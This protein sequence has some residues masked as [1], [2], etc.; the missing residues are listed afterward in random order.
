VAL[1]QVRAVARRDEPGEQMTKRGVRFVAEPLAAAGSGT[2]DER[3]VVEQRW[4]A[5][6]EMGRRFAAGIGCLS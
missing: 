6:D 1:A 4:D 3:E 5:V 2:L